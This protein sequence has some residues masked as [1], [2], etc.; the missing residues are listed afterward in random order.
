M[1]HNNRDSNSPEY[2]FDSSFMDISRSRLF[3]PVQTLPNS[4]PPNAILKLRFENKGLDAICL[5][6]ILNHRSL[7]SKIPPHFNNTKPCISYSYTRTIA[8][9][10]FNYKATL[11]DIDVNAFMSDHPICSC[12]G[13]PFIY[14]PNGHI[15]T[16][17][18]GSNV[19]EDLVPNIENHGLSV[20]TIFV[21]PT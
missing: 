1:Q 20:G 16:G 15:V 11:R 12:D 18:V 14:Q 6:N 17:N 13:S 9:K 7:C 4:D 3:K 19:L 5:S 8:S 21:I 2:R 10:I